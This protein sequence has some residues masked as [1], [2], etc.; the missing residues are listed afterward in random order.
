LLRLSTKMKDAP[1]ELQR[2][3]R[4]V[5][6]KRFGGDVLSY[7]TPSGAPSQ[8]ARTLHEKYGA[9]YGLNSPSAAQRFI[10]QVPKAAESP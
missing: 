3:A 5:L 6:Q 2:V 4:E 7:Q 1:K 10:N 8:L 9:A